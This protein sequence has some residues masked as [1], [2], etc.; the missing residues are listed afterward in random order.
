MKYIVAIDD[1]DM[2]GTR[3]TGRLLQELSE[4]IES[5]HHGTCSGISRH[6]LFID[7]EIPY[8][9]HNSAMCCEINLTDFNLNEFIIYCSEFLGKNSITGSDPG[10]CIA[11]PDKILNPEKLIKFGQDA[12]T[13]VLQKSD[14]YETAGN[15]GLH[16]SEHGGT[17]A[18]IIG[19]LAGVGLR[20]AG[21]DGR[22][23]G[24]YRLGCPGEVVDAASFCEQHIAEQVVAEDGRVLGGME[25][26]VIGAEKIKTIRLSGRRVVM[27]C[28]Y[29]GWSEA[30]D[31]RYRTMTREEVRKI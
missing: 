5:G 19:A 16:L 27:V 30:G 24:W 3:G 18:G 28:P 14:A 2:P 26:L 29:E 15:A 21:N 11:D 7:E 25:K 22:Y 12:K 10:L 23:R 8:T 13:T 20:L 6:Q 4:K 1:T 31:V 17:G 9:S